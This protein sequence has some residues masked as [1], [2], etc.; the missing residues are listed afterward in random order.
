MRLDKPAKAREALDR[1]IRAEV[2]SD[3]EAQAILDG[4]F[5]ASEDDQG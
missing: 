5:V 3:A 1:G 2:V 4:D